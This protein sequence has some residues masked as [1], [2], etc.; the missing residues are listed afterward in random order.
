MLFYCY[1]RNSGHWTVFLKPVFDPT[2]KDFQFISL[3]S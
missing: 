3:N 1:T 2:S